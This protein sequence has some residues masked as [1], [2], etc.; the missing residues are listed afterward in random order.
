MIG[1][2]NLTVLLGAMEPVLG[3][4]TYVFCN[5]KRI[6]EK[7]DLDRIW[8]LVREDEAMTLILEKAT[9]DNADLPYE[10]LFSRITLNIHSSL[11]AVGLT[12][13]VATKLSA[14]GIS[15]NV[16]AAYYHDHI[17]IQQEKSIQALAALQELIEENN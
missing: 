6:D 15:A 17:F 16:V 4:E 2:T 12:A 14:Y 9:A 1:E 10:S 5:V 11:D 13:A 7:M 8:A 3:E